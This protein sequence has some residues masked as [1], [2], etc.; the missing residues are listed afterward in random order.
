MTAAC[1]VV[2]LGHEKRTPFFAELV[3]FAENGIEI[4]CAEQC[5]FSLAYRL[6]RADPRRV[7]A[8][9]DRI[10]FAAIIRQI[11]QI[12]IG[13]ILVTGSRDDLLAPQPVRRGEEAE[14]AFQNIQNDSGS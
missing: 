5:R 13:K 6:L 2:E 11:L 3:L 9:E 12:D 1:G 14:N 4:F 10:E 8:G 7:A